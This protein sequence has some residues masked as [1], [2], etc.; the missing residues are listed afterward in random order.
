MPK[1]S[2][3][4]RPTPTTFF[5]YKTKKKELTKVNSFLVTPTGFKPVTF[6]S[7]VRCSIQLSY[8]AVV[9]LLRVQRYNIF[10]NY[11]NFLQLFYH[12]FYNSLINNDKNLHE[13]DIST[14]KTPFHH[15]KTTILTHFTTTRNLYFSH[16]TDFCCFL[17]LFVST[18]SQ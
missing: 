1:K 11:Q 9:S 14:P 7:V 3:T 2:D 6:A 18:K 15:N 16:F 8:G 17:N 5:Q 13:T 4:T 10:P 12:I